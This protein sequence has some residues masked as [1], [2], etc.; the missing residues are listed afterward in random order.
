MSEKKSKSE[1]N[2]NYDNFLMGMLSTI[3]IVDMLFYFMTHISEKVHYFS[4]HSDNMM[5]LLTKHVLISVTIL[6]FSTAI[7]YSSYRHIRKSFP[8][9]KTLIKFFCI[10]L[11]FVM[12]FTLIVVFYFRDTLL[13]LVPPVLTI[14]FIC[15]GWWIQSMTTSRANK[16]SHTLN[17]L[18]SSRGNNILIENIAKYDDL[19]SPGYILDSDICAEHYKDLDSV[20]NS[21][22]VSSANVKEKLN[23]GIR[24][25]KYVLNH[26]E[27]ISSAI[28]SGDLDEAL[29]KNCNRSYFI[30]TEKELCY[31]IIEARK[32]QTTA[33]ENFLTIVEKWSDK[34]P[35]SKTM[36]NKQF[37][38]K[39]GKRAPKKQYID[40]ISSNAS[41][42]ESISMNIDERE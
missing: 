20:G 32:T 5:Y 17:V 23:E 34:E 25:C 4:G 35:Y 13:G 7:P 21:R 41:N 27:F 28:L 22:G 16:R 36:I 10:L 12:L 1:V 6:V 8:D 33:C 29:I 37:D 39:I 11:A 18:L 19:V 9:T 30:N 31:L 26:Y 2:S 14:Y 15:M 38:E 24:A 42:D 40:R 3:F